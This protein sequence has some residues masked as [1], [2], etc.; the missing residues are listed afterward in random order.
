MTDEQKAACVDWC[1]FQ[2]E[3]VAL[4]ARAQRMAMLSDWWQRELT[5]V[6]ARAR[7]RIESRSRR[8]QKPTTAL[9]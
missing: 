9:L 7:Y 8:A 3:V 4:R 1:N 6:E 2:D 5:S